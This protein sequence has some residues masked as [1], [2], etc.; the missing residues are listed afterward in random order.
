MDDQEDMCWILSKLLSERGHVVRTAQCRA[1][2]RKAIDDFDCQVA[3]VDY[4]LPDSNGIALITEMTSKLPALRSILMTSYGSA[5]VRGQAV[6]EKVFAYV[7]KPF[8]NG[9][10]IEVIEAGIRVWEASNAKARSRAGPG[11]HPPPRTP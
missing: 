8:K 10:M 9:R 1:R 7:E 3:V 5:A 4:R 2:A 6:A 11:R